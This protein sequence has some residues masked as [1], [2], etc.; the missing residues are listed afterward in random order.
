MNTSLIRHVAKFFP[1][2]LRRW[3]AR[4]LHAR[5]YRGDY[6]NWAEARAL[7]A[8]YDAGVI[9]EKAVAAT[10]LVRDGHVAFER[11]TVLFKEPDIS[12][13]VLDAVRAVARE[14]GGRLSVLDFGG[15]LGSTWWQH[16]RWLEDLADVRWSV[17]EQEGFVR[18]GQCEFTTGPLRFYETVDA[19]FALEQPNVVLLSSVLPYLES[20]HALLADLARR[21]CDW[22]I[23]DRTGFTLRGRDWLTVQHVPESIYR[24]SYPCWFFDRDRLLAPLAM[25]WRVIA[26]WPTFDG[27]ANGFEYRGL[28]LRRIRATHEDPVV[29]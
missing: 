19:C 26:E 15:A 9:L 8:G 23:I 11:D 22:I 17:V 6:P 25:E 1:K 4:R 13:P 24:A 29:P 12:K 21:N 7:S 16:R 18:A 27:E 2:A 28:M 20:P 5:I 3:V 14:A 10:R